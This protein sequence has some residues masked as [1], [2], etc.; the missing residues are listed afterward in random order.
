[1]SPHRLHCCFVAV[2]CWLATAAPSPTE[3]Q[4][5]ALS[6]NLANQLRSILQV[7]MSAGRVTAGSQFNGRSMNSSTQS[8]DRQE[9]LAIDLTGNAPSIDYELST[10][11]FRV[12]VDMDEGNVLRILRTPQAEGTSKKFE[13]RQPSEG[14]LTVTVGENPPE[15]TYQAD[16][17]WHL[18]IAE[19]ELTRTELEPLLRLLRP[20][21]PLVSEATAIEQAL[22]KQ[23][24]VTRGFDRQS[25]SVLV[26]QLR[27]PS[28]VE[29]LEADRRLRELGQVVVPYLR[30]MSTAELD[31]EQNYRIRT[32]IRRYGSGA[33]ED[34]PE[35]ASTWL[36][37]DPEVWYAL[38]ARADAKHRETARA[39]LALL[40]GEAVVLDADA[41]G[42]ALAAQLATIRKQ[43][44]RRQRAAA[45]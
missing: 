42:D 22:F 1:M 28:Y 36:A 13:F 7:R 44:D 2:A 4:E 10:Q 18:A 25:W 5:I 8:Q 31:A 24:D 20:G 40:L 19:P 37:A 38:A 34:S 30:N 3:A 43:I 17:V 11:G 27:S 15:K 35:T 26:G 21:W 29:R 9:K 45:P 33:T 32:I 12:I 14:K 41:T 23:V 6:P 39:Q 16:S